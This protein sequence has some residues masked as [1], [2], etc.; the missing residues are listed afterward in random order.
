MPTWAP[1]ITDQ[2]PSTVMAS[3]TSALVVRSWA[4][5]P[6]SSGMSRERNPSSPA[7]RTSLRT[8]GKSFAS[9]AAAAGS[10]RSSAN[11][12]ALR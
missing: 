6:Y 4:R 5:P 7:S 8:T 11:L 2:V 12:R 10:T 3:A 1:K 9:M